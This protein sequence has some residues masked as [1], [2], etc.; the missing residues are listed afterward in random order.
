VKAVQTRYAEIGADV[1]D[2]AQLEA[3]EKLMSGAPE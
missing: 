2:L 3:V 1:D